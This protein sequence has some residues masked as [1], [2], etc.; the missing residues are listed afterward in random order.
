MTPENWPLPLAA[1]VLCVPERDLRDLVR[2]L[3]LKPSGTANM[4]DFSTQGRTSRVYPAEH[5]ILI[6]ESI[7][8]LRD[9]VTKG[10]AL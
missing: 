10:D 1:K 4:R 6:C 8:V 5:L 2:M 7:A 3:G 9:A